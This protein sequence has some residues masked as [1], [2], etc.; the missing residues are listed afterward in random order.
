MQ[1]GTMQLVNSRSDGSRDINIIQS[2]F[3]QNS[4]ILSFRYYNK[5]KG[6]FFE[7]IDSVHGT[8]HS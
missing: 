6:H 8:E 1:L 2:Q 5:G 7:T 4:K 3:L